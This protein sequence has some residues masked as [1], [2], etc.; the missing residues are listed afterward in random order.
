[1][2][3]MDKRSIP[4][5]PMFLLLLLG[6]F[7]YWL[8]QNIEYEEFEKQV[9][10]S[11]LAKNNNFLAAS[12]LLKPQGINFDVAK[13]RRIFR[14]LNNEDTGLLWIEQLNILQT[15]EEQR[16]L[17]QWVEN[18][19]MLLTSLA[20]SGRNDQQSIADDFLAEVGI[21]LSHDLPADTD[22]SRNRANDNTPYAT[23]KI[24]NPIVLGGKAA[25]GRIAMVQSYGYKLELTDNAELTP[26]DVLLDEDNIIQLRIGEGFVTVYGDESQFDNQHIRVFDHAFLLRWL[27]QP[28]QNKN[29][30]IAFEL[31]DT[32]KLLTTIWKTVPLAV[33]SFA[34]VLAG[35][36]CMASMRLGPIEKETTPN[37]SNLLAHLKARGAFWHKHGE[38]KALTLTVKDA[39]LHKLAKRLGTNLHAMS[40]DAAANATQAASNQE[41]LSAR[42]VP[43]E[44]QRLVSLAAQI[45][46][47][48]PEAAHNALFETPRNNKQILQHSQI[49]QTILQSKSHSIQHINNNASSV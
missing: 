23:H 13:N 34:L 48:S 5:F 35:Y 30:I 21:K 2:N 9:E 39:A 10:Q 11:A 16:D 37:R 36:L 38:N 27:T 17:L 43:A 20:R 25:P 7:A 41:P 44:Q 19:G 42:L 33:I 47:C 6:V 22:K 46:L 4:F 15:A 28:A 1:M 40:D 12:R 31:D 29:A 49:L 32:P 26:S 18:G 24:F 3:P 45:A 8:Y 14:K